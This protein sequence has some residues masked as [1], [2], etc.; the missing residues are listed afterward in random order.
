MI[1]AN[2]GRMLCMSGIK[3]GLFTGL[4]A[5]AS[6]MPVF[7]NAQPPAPGDPKTGKTEKVAKKLVH[8]K[9]TQAFIYS[10]SEHGIGLHLNRGNDNAKW[11]EEDIQKKFADYFASHGVKGKVFVDM[12]DVPNTSGIIFVNGLPVGEDKIVGFDE[13]LKLLPTAV[14]KQKRLFGEIERAP[15]LSKN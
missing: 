8:S 1:A 15:S 2:C 4:L 12:Y 11:T 3:N 14:D 7:S 5:V 9:G 13:L 6:L 10:E